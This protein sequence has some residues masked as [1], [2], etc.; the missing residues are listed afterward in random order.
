MRGGSTIRGRLSDQPDQHQR[1]ES[2]RARFAERRDYREPTWWALQFTLRNLVQHAVSV[3]NGTYLELI[4][5]ISGENVGGMDAAVEPTGTYSR[6]FP[7]EI[8]GNIR[9]TFSLRSKVSA[10]RLRA[11][12]TLPHYIVYTICIPRAYRIAMAKTKIINFRINAE[13]KDLSLIHI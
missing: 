8:I 7:E 11:H 9:P 4:S 6:R 10:I 5:V 12:F 3:T 2:D 13:L 1:D